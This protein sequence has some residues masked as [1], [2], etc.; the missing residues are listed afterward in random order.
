MKYAGRYV[1][2]MRIT[3]TLHLVHAGCFSLVLALS[4]CGDD[5][6]PTPTT[7][8]GMADAGPDDLAVA[9]AGPSDL[10]VLPLCESTTV[11]CV[12]E[13]IAILDLFDVANPAAITEQGT[14][15]GEFT[16]LID[17]TGGGMT[18]SLSFVYARFT[19]TGLAKVDISDEDALVSTDWD[20]A[21]RRYVFRVNSGVG[22]PSCVQAARTEPSTTFDTLSAVPDPA[23]IT[24]RTESYLTDTCEIVPDGAGLGSPATALSSFWSYP[25]CVSMTGNVYVVALRGGRHVKLQVLGYYTPANQTSCDETGMISL[26]SGAGNVRVRWA[27]LD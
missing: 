13:S 19:D 8:L 24:Y 17:A 6:T 11:P 20:I 7:D 14:T 4:A 16:T 3:S 23:S 5:D 1:T 26:P 21:F 9:D 10:G 15:A 12:D 22:G 25:G 18:P 27:F 2:P